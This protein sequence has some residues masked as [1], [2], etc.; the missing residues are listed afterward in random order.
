[1][2][3]AR[4]RL[5]RRIRKAPSSPV[6]IV[7]R[8]AAEPAEWGPNERVAARIM[9]PPLEILMARG[10][11]STE[12]YNAAKEIERVFHWVTSGLKSH[13]GDLTRIRGAVG[14]ASD[15]LQAAYTA[16]Y[17][18][19]ADALS[20]QRVTAPDV[21]EMTRVL[22]SVGEGD[23]IRLAAKA[24]DRRDRR[25]CRRHHPKT[26]QFVI[27]FVID[28]RTFETIAREERHHHKTVKRAVLDGLTLYAEIAGWLRRVG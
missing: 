20:Q 8:P 5:K 21:T 12:Q 7:I 15:P 9:P 14:S 23:V 11:I 22:A 26:L 19:W 6:P 2:T 13:I 24:G 27:D 28:D 4:Q 16:R 18:P 25:Q 1:M 3:T 10:L 17:R